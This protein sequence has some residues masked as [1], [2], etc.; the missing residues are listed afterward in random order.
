MGTRFVATE[1][2]PVHRNVK[3]W[4]VNSAENETALVMRSLRNTER[5]LRNPISDKVIEMESQGASLSELAPLL[6][7][8]RGYKVITDGDIDYGLAAAGQIVGLIRS[9]PTIQEL[10]DTIMTEAKEIVS[11]RLAAGILC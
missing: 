8:K 9:I 6:S 11:D 1:E 5:V 10:V 4:L 3:E 2:T 7:G